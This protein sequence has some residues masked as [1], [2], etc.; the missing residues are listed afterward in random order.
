MK[1]TQI[2]PVSKSDFRGYLKTAIEYI[3]G[4]R[5]HFSKER[6][7]ATCGDCVHGMIAANDALTI[8]FLGR[9]SI[10]HQHTDT[11][12]LLKQVAPQ[13]DQL[14]KEITRFQR[15]LGLKHAAEYD[16]GKVN[17]HDAEIALKDA[18]RFLNF[19]RSRIGH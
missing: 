14:S 1:K 16:G 5:D 11:I 15:V 4:A 2:R 8:F 18:E 3:E 17:H 13:D 6:F 12:H 7:I 9:K 10:S 19:I